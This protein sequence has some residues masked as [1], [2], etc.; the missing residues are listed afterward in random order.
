VTEIAPPE[1]VETI[2][3]T[4]DP[5]PSAAKPK[6]RTTPSLKAIFDAPPA[7]DAPVATQSAG[8]EPVGAKELRRAWDQFA[9]QRT[10]QAAEYQIMKRE[11]DFHFPTITLLLTNPVE[12]SLL[13]NFRR[14]LTQHLRDTLKNGEITIT[15]AMQEKGGKKVIYTSK[16]KF[17]HL[18]EKNPYLNELKDRLGLDWEF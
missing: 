17:E 13:D 18:A 1:V 14:E 12:E 8:K 6:T 15:T 10:D 2:V 16:E 11:Y 7:V 4:T 3:A 5:A 9:E